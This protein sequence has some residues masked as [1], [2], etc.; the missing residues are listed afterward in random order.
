MTLLPEMANMHLLC[1]IWSRKVHHYPSL[2][3]E[4]RRLHSLHQQRAQL[5]ANKLVA[6]EDIN[7]SR[8][9]NLSLPEK[10]AEVNISYIRLN[11]VFIEEDVARKLVQFYIFSPGLLDA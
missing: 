9:G 1:D 10:M 11:K 7:E 6:Q 3:S 2:R 8:S 4:V 5:F